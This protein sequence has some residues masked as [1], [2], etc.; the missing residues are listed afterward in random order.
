MI[1]VL[2]GT[3]TGKSRNKL[4]N[5]ISTLLSKKP[6]AMLVRA[7]SE[8]FEESFLEEHIESQGLFES[9]SIVVLDTVFEN[10]IYKKSVLKKL[11]EL[12]SSEN[13]FIILEGKLDS[14][15]LK[16][17]EEYATK[18]QEC[19]LPKAKEDK[20]NI[21]ELS[22][23]LGARNRKKLWV[24]YQEGKVHNISNEEMHGI[25]FWGTKN[26]IL[27]KKA[28]TSSESGLS[29]F[30]YRK[31]SVSAK[32]YSE[33]ELTNMARTLVQMYHQARRGQVPLGIAFERFVLELK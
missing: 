21:F 11:K 19:A 25:A 33:N 1:Y 2:Y 27:S 10:E 24:I 17:L 32:N 12:Q 29:P 15:S 14:K 16:K 31:A 8:N 5:L 22:D 18:V 23:A 20:F 7:N 13:I 6:D 4:S 30:V 28:K 9:K 3:D 26:M